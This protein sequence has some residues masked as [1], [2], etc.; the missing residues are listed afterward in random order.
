MNLPSQSGHVAGE[1]SAA[2]GRPDPAARLILGVK[3]GVDLCQT[4]LGLAAALQVEVE[5]RCALVLHDAHSNGLL[6]SYD[7]AAP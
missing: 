5:Q 3:E 4:A 7:Q 1:K 6:G 2:L